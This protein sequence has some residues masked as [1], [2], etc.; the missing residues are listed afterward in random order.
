VTNA[1]AGTSCASAVLTFWFLSHGG[2]TPIDAAAF[3]TTIV[4]ATYDSAHV[5]YERS[6]GKLTV[7]TVGRMWAGERVVERFDLTGV[8]AGTA[9]PAT[10]VFALNAYV[11]DSCGGGGCGAY[12]GATL[13]AGTDSVGVE[14][15][16]PG[17]CDS[18]AK[19]LNTTLSVPVTFVAG[20][21]LVTA[22]AM[23][24]HTS[25]VG[26]GR[27]SAVG[28]YGVAGLPAGVRATTCGGADLTPVRRRTWG[29]L[30]ATYR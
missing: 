21:P 18:C 13:T 8:P 5:T 17:P 1:Q 22:F 24:Y 30:K 25:N 14:A 3:D 19:Q 2:D 26:W 23:L 20:T 6:A 29:E 15:N 7:D 27:V 12:F 4:T 9:V 28:V 10:I 16:V 11:L